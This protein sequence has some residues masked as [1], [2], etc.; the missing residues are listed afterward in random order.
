[1][2]DIAAEAA[3]SYRR[4]VEW[5]PT[6]SGLVPDP[7]MVPRE[8]SGLPDLRDKIDAVLVGDEGYAL[9]AFRA[10]RAAGYETITIRAS[11]RAG[12]E[13]EMGRYREARSLGLISPTLT[14]HGYYDDHGPTRVAVVTTE[15]LHGCAEACGWRRE[16]SHDGTAF[17]AVTM[18]DVRAWAEGRGQWYAEIIRPPMHAVIVDPRE[19]RDGD[20]SMAGDGPG[21]AEPVAA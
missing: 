8:V 17:L 4:L 15:A 9:V 7:T 20:E 13:S 10:L 11:D 1:M 12:G 5:W 16:N 14:I 21:S 6:I 18:D 2:A 3:E 19:R